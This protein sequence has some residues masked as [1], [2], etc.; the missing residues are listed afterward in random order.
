M[1]KNYMKPLIPYVGTNNYA[2]ESFESALTNAPSNN[3][4]KTLFAEASTAERCNFLEA[5]SE[6]YN[7][8][9]LTKRQALHLIS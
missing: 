7:S 4:L 9:C 3:I 8:D 6:M 2:K 1:V 5:V